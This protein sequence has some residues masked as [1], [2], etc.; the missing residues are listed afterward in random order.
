MT[1]SATFSFGVNSTVFVSVF[2]ELSKAG[3]VLSL[4]T[5]IKS[6]SFELF[7]SISTSLILSCAML[8][9]SSIVVFFVTLF[10]IFI[11]SFICVFGFSV[12]T[13]LKTCTVLFAQVCICVSSI[14]ISL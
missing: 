3:S 10:C 14:L 13:L 4:M 2:I 11:S 12:L 9:S 5:S 6:E 8:I 7:F 1:D